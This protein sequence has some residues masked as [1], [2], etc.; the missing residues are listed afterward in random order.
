MFRIPII[1]LPF[2]AHAGLDGQNI[3]IPSP[4]TGYVSKNSVSRFTLLENNVRE[5][6]DLA[7]SKFSEWFMPKKKM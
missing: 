6:E 5:E 4:Q 3:H 2:P 1:L 7:I